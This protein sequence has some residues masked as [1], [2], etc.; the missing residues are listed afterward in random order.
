[1]ADLK[2]IQEKYCIDK[3][4]TG[5]VGVFGGKGIA[6]KEYGKLSPGTPEMVSKANLRRESKNGGYKY[7]EFKANTE[8]LISELNNTMSKYIPKFSGDKPMIEAI[9]KIRA[10]VATLTKF[11]QQRRNSMYKTKIDMF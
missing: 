7:E 11:A 6:A 8:G 1:M 5:Q 10:S 4:Q 2:K 3:R 9:K